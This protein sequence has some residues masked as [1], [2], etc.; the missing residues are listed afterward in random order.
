MFLARLSDS[1]SS[2]R[3]GI[4]LTVLCTTGR[5]D[6][7]HDFQH[8]PLEVRSQMGLLPFSPAAHVELF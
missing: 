8:P 4:S 1:L 3:S 2:S 5:P 6:K 7:K